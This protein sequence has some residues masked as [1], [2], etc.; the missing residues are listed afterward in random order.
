M[1]LKVSSEFAKALTLHGEG[2]ILEIVRAWEHRCDWQRER[3]HKRVAIA[4]KAKN[5][6]GKKK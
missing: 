5:G 1:S 4:K 6:K 2:K 3:Y